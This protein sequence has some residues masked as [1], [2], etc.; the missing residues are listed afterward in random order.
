M[1]YWALRRG[2]ASCFHPRKPHKRL[3]H[4]RER[5]PKTN[6]ILSGLL[7]ETPVN[8]LSES[9]CPASSCRPLS[10]AT[11]ETHF[12]DGRSFLFHTQLWFP[13]L[14]LSSTSLLVGFLGLA[15]EII[16][17]MSNGTSKKHHIKFRRSSTRKHVEWQWRWGMKSGRD[18]RREAKTAN[19][20]WSRLS[21]LTRAL[22]FN[23]CS[24]RHLP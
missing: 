3:I 4:L 6:K 5:S 7:G 21:F 9:A 16:T 10:H 22:G 20:P 11:R 2:L 15:L 18:A 8:N 12:L 17:R 13:E 1:V 24:G 14:S 19:T 23:V